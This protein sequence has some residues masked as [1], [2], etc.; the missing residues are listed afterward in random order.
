MENNPK[1][2]EEEDLDEDEDDLDKESKKFSIFSKEKDKDQ[3]E[4]DPKEKKITILD[5]ILNTDKA[6]E[7]EEQASIEELNEA[8]INDLSKVIAQDRLD[9]IEE[10]STGELKSENLAA[11]TYL[12]NVV[13]SGEVEQSFQKTV[14][15]LKIKDSIDPNLNASPTE[16][17][18]D[19]QK[20]DSIVDDSIY[21]QNIPKTE[22]ISPSSYVESLNDPLPNKENNSKNKKKKSKSLALSS[23]LVESL[24]QRREPRLKN[25]SVDQKLKEVLNDRVLE[26]S[27]R[28]D[29]NEQKIRQVSKNMDILTKAELPIIYQEVR[30]KRKARKE[31][32]RTKKINESP[33]AKNEFNTK[34]KIIKKLGTKE[35]LNVASKIEIDKTSL[36]K[37]YLNRLITEKGLRRLVEAYFRGMNIKNVLKKEL[38]QKEIDFERDPKLR[39]KGVDLGEYHENNINIEQLLKEKGI[40]WNEQQTIKEDNTSQTDHNIVSLKQ[41]PS[42]QKTLKLGDIVLLGLILILAIIVIIILI[43]KI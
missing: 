32:E 42:S 34:R 38:I 2:L 41:D 5:Q 26:I 18:S 30:D 22:T 8:E 17:S 14:E 21:S 19:D 37:I 40:E 25:N 6:P 11:Q 15:K 20:K 4:P 28:I 13:L 43:K 3:I 24:F 9:A 10:D 29:N 39:D 33:E 12:E 27:Q 31:N 16:F 36:K 1:F 35:L 7:L 23:L